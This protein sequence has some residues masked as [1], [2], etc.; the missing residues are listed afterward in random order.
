[1][2]NLVLDLDTGIDDAIAL[3]IAAKDERIN[4]LGVTCTYGNV[5]VDESV[6]NTLALLSL[7]NRIDVPVYRG[8][9]RALISTST[10]VP[11]EAGRKIHG[12][13]GSGDIS[14]KESKR[15]AE[16]TNAIKIKAP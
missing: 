10:Y 8:R 13:K 16:T 14:L 9:D 6:D 15:K 5:T 11:H 1:M 4:L 12:K 3:T 7:L 2:I